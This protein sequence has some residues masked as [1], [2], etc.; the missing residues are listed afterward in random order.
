[1]LSLLVGKAAA[2]LGSESSA[3]PRESHGIPTGEEPVLLLASFSDDESTVQRG[4]VTT[5]VTLQG[6]FTSWGSSSCPSIAKTP[7]G[8]GRPGPKGGALE[9]LSGKGLGQWPG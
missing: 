6:A 9:Y 7:T 4:K 5:K 3:L 1:M 8:G 2:Q